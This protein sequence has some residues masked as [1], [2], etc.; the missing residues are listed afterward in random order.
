MLSLY[1]EQGEDDSKSVIEEQFKMKVQIAVILLCCGSV[2]AEEA[3]RIVGGKNATV[4]QFPFHVQI[5]AFIQFGLTFLCGASV[6]SPEY[7]ITAGE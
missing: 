4:G 7:I 1:K 3:N 6:I 5:R 2:F